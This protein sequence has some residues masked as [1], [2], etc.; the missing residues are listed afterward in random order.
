MGIKWAKPFNTKLRGYSCQIDMGDGDNF[1]AG[2]ASPSFYKN[3]MRSHNK[4]I[5]H[6][7]NGH[8]CFQAADPAAFN[9]L[10]AYNG[11]RP[12]PHCRYGSNELFQ[13]TS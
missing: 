9:S 1:E 3:R 5:F 2:M 11:S 12:R 4:F 10:I 6:Q 13:E 8:L 7:G